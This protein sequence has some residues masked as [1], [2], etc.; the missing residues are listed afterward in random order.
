MC[1]DIYPI[2]AAST[3]SHPAPPR[4]R[5]TGAYIDSTHSHPCGVAR[6]RLDVHYLQAP[7]TRGYTTEERFVNANNHHEGI[8]F[9]NIYP[10]FH[11]SGA[12]LLPHELGVVEPTTPAAATRSKSVPALAPAPASRGVLLGRVD[13]H[14]IVLGGRQRLDDDWP[15][16]VVLLAAVPVL[17]PLRSPATTD[18]PKQ[19]FDVDQTHNT[20]HLQTER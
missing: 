17:G 6:R 12:A 8:L 10:T 14:R 18:N 9:G 5:R 7:K 20:T 1:N 4:R 13:R 2:P 16:A 11:P 15:P 19:L 3:S